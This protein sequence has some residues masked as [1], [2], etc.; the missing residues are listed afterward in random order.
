MP[1]LKQNDR[2]FEYLVD[3]MA[4]SCQRFGDYSFD[5]FF[6]GWEYGFEI[7]VTDNSLEYMDTV[8]FCEIIN[9]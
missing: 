6:I 2:F 3:N 5:R 1:K 8:L 4:F 7:K 9:A